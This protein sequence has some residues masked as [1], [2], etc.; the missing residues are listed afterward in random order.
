MSRIFNSW[1]G[2][3]GRDR[4]GILEKRKLWKSYRVV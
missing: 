3:E 2:E 1:D 4:E